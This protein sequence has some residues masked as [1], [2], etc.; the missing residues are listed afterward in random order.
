MN[1]SEPPVEIERDGQMVGILKP[2]KRPSWALLPHIDFLK[3]DSRGCF[4]A[5][6]LP[7]TMSD[8]HGTFTKPAT[9]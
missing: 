9:W 1:H 7:T 6:Q 3:A 2:L 8:Q 5:S 4:L